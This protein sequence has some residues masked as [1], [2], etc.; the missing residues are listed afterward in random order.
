MN[1]NYDYEDVTAEMEWLELDSYCGGTIL[2]S[3]FVLTSGGCC[4]EVRASLTPL[5]KVELGTDKVVRIAQNMTIHPQYKIAVED[6]ADTD[7]LCL[8]RIEKDLFYSGTEKLNT[9]TW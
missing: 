8:I 4:A 3:H 6:G 5:P 1:T 7:D 2:S 9:G